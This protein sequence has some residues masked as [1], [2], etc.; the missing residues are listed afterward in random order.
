LGKEKPVDGKEEDLLLVEE[1]V[2]SNNARTTYYNHAKSRKVCC[3][4]EVGVSE[5]DR[6]VAR[7]QEN[8]QKKEVTRFV[9]FRPKSI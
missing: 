5:E 6:P 7:N 4:N 2:H 8:H 3:N 1:G 9:N